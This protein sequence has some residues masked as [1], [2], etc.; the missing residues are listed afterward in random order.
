MVNVKAVLDLAKYKIA[1]AITFTTLAGFILYAGGITVDLLWAVIGVFFLSSG[2]MALNQLQER[3]YDAQMRRTSKRPLPSG[4]MTTKQALLWVI[5][6]LGSGTALL[7]FFL[8]ISTV[9]LGLINV[10]WY[11][12]VYTPLK[13]VTPFAVV[14]GSVIGA[15]PAL[16][17]WCAAGGS[18]FDA[19]IWIV[20]LFL[21]L[22]QIPHFWL[23]LHYYNDD[24]EQ[25][26]FPGIER[27]FSHNNIKYIIFVWVLATSF[28]S[29]LFPMFGLITRPV[30]VVGL[31]L[32]N[33]TLIYFFFQLL[34]SKRP[35]QKIISFASINLYMIVVLCFSMFNLFL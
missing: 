10:I 3:N 29:F 2:A 24:Y 17:G 18:L 34:T 9:M 20:A 19:Q 32:A 31:I 1:I 4:T 27:V 6:F 30:L 11:N 13:R 14:P 33:I 26:G 22:W 16:L 12:L 21:F 28:S 7:Y 25:G 35:A 5:F 23:I 8:P 15:V